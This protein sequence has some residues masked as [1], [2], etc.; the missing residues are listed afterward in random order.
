VSPRERSAT[1]ENPLEYCVDRFLLIL[2]APFSGGA[3]GRVAPSNH[4]T[5]IYSG[6]SVGLYPWIVPG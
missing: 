3:D 6:E 2:L 5:R 4:R 1:Q